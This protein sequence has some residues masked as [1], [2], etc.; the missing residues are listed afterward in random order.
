MKN[1][2]FTLIE[3]LVVVLIIG[4]LVAIAV[5]QYQKAVYKTH[6]NNLMD[7]TKSI[8]QAEE[9]Y[10]L[11]NGKYT[12]DLTELDISLPGCT[13]SNSKNRCSF[14]WGGCY[15]SS[16]AP[17]VPANASCYDSKGIYNGY[18]HFF[19]H[20]DSDF[21]SK[22]QCYAYSGDNPSSR[23]GKWDKVCNEAGATKFRS[24]GNNSFGTN[25]TKEINFWWF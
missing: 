3:L 17:G 18:L 1:Q 20:V 24:Q 16:G 6:Y 5:P 25:Q 2:A 14:D 12:P 15:V 11:A 10:Y 9:L 23:K 22:R 7:I 21:K 4:I 13:L 8:Y 19:D